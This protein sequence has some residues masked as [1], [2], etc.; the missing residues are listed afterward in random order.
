MD[1]KAVAEAMARKYHTRNP[2][3]LA[4]AKKI[5]VLFEPLGS[6]MGFYN[7][8]YRQSFIHIN[9]EL[10][11]YQSTF[12]C[13]HELG[14]AILHAKVN[15]PFLRKHTMFSVDRLELEANRFAI[16]LLYSDEELKDFLSR[17]IDDAATYMG[18][19]R[20][21]AEYRLKNI[22]KEEQK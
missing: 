4:E 10:D 5:I 18:V 11:G 3:D 19:P 1:I 14:H 9:Q 8:C 15:T 13:A 16:T 22:L 7:R 2:F 6:I 12:T 20:K 21:L 17:P